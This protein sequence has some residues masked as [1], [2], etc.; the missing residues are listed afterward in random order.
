MLDY[1]FSFDPITGDVIGPNG[2]ASGATNNGNLS[3]GLGG[4]WVASGHAVTISLEAIAS[5]TTTVTSGGSVNGTGGVTV[6]GG[7]GVGGTLT[8]GVTL[9]LGT[10]TPDISTARKEKYVTLEVEQYEW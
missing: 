7:S 5:V 10:T 6:G 9:T 8:G 4:K 1:Q 3:G 2:S